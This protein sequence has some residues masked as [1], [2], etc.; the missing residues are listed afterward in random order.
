MIQVHL[1][2]IDLIQHMAQV[3]FRNVFNQIIN[4]KKQMSLIFVQGRGTITSL[5]IIRSNDVFSI[6]TFKKSAEA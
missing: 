4:N 2:G 5:T 1:G 3:V 6:P